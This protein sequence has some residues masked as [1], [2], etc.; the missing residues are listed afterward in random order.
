MGNVEK[1]GRK[2]AQRRAADS[3]AAVGDDDAPAAALIGQRALEDA[4]HVNVHGQISARAK[5]PPRRGR[6]VERRKHFR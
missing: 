2:Q 4:E 5:I 3:G 6:V 1:L